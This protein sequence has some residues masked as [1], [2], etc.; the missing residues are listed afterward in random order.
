MISFEEAIKYLGCEVDVNQ[1]SYSIS[2]L[3]KKWGCSKQTARNIVSAMVE[4]KTAKQVRKYL[5]DKCGRKQF[6]VSYI[7]AEQQEAEKKEK[8]KTC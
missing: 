3:S 6:V 7:F 1:N 2:E 5:V 4:K 8:K